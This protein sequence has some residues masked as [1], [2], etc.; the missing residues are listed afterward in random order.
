[1]RKGDDVR[2]F[3]GQGC[4]HRASV[5]EASKRGVRIKVGEQITQEVE[6]PLRI[7]LVQGVSRNERMD[8]VMQKSTELG[9]WRITPVLCERSVVRL[10]DERAHSR[11]HHW[12]NI[13]QSA[14]EQC[15]RNV[16]PIVD[17]PLVLGDWLDES[18]RSEGLRLVLE[19]G[20]EC[21]M[22]SVQQVTEPVTI[23]VGPEGG[24]T[25]FEYERLRS[26]GFLCIGLGPRIMRTETAALVAVALLQSSYGD[27][28]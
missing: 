5:L 9:V 22:R 18:A 14:C 3:D 4:E 2:V 8:L 16:L 10:D 26:T 17:P 12:Q 25:D 19:H 20:A 24:L 13:A 23:L 28:N 15:G 27:L 21:G 11:H 1:M 6:S 7:H